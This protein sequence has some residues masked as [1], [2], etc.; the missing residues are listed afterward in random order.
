MECF[1]LDMASVTNHVLVKKKAGCSCTFAVCQQPQDDVCHAMQR[2]Q[3][4]RICMATGQYPR[5]MS[6]TFIV[7]RRRRKLSWFAYVFGHDTLPKIILLG[8]GEGSCRRGR[9][10]K[11]W[12]NTNNDRTVQSLSSLLRIADDRGRWATI[13][14]EASVGIPANEVGRHELV[15]S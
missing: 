14:A 10:R 4:E 8:T 15:S 6:A 1:C 11:S 13:A 9:P 2:T 7:N 12:R 5:R 3:N